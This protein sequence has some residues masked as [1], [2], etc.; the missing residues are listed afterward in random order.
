MGWIFEMF[1]AVLG[2]IPAIVQGFLGL[3]GMMFGL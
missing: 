3:F 2:I 1:Y